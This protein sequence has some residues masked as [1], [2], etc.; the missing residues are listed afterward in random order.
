M[1]SHSMDATVR[2]R[3]VYRHTACL[4]LVKFSRL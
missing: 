2:L 3:E 4:L 1:S